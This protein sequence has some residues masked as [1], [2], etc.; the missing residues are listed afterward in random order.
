MSEIIINSPMTVMI[1]DT[2]LGEL[3]GAIEKAKKMHGDKVLVESHFSNVKFVVSLRD[4]NQES[5]R[6]VPTEVSLPGRESLSLS[7]EIEKF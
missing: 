1:T 3:V 2:T 4:K 6:Y 5:L 7:E